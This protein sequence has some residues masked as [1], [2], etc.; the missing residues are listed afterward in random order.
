MWLTLEEHDILG[1]ALCT[2]TINWEIAHVCSPYS[3]VSYY[4]MPFT[5]ISGRKIRVILL[6]GK[7]FWIVGIIS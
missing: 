7:A 5:R 6:V 2:Q 3:L 4:E 1:I